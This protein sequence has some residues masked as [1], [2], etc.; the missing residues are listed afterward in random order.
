MAR[1]ARQTP[2]RTALAGALVLLLCAGRALGAGAAYW[3]GPSMYPGAVEAWL[4]VEHSISV[5]CSPPRGCYA[6][7]QWINAIVNCRQR[8]VGLLRVVSMNING[9][10]VNEASGDAL[11]FLRPY[12]QSPLSY[13]GPDAEVLRIVCSDVSERR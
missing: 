2:R 12:G 9:D 8:T 10:V 6:K 13:E 3:I 11:R 5:D 7:S 4:H 1:S